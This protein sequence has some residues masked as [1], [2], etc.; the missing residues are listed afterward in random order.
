MAFNYPVGTS[1][2]AGLVLLIPVLAGGWFLVRERVAAIAAE[3][4][5]ALE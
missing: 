4:G 2:I 1:T 5:G 3:R